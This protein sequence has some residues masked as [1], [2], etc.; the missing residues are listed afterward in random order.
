MHNDQGRRTKDEGRVIV[1][2]FVFRLSSLVFRLERFLDQLLHPR[3]L[4]GDNRHL[5]AIAQPP[6]N[7]LHQALE[8]AAEQVSRREERIWEPEIGGWRLEIGHSRIPNL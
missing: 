3:G 6:D 2:L 4:R 8:L 5:L 1:D 7:V